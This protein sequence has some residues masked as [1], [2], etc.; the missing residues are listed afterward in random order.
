ML[1]NGKQEMNMMLKKGVLPFV[2]L[3]SSFVVVDCNA[4][5]IA[6]GKIKKWWRRKEET[7]E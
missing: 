3:Y 2:R 7:K 1:V 6:D 5:A 4:S